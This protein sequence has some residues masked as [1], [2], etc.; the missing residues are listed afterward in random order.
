MGK[1]PLDT[2][3]FLSQDRTGQKHNATFPQ[4]ESCWNG[5]QPD[6]NGWVTSTVAGRAGHVGAQSR[7]TFAALLA[8]VAAQTG[9]LVA[10]RPARVDRVVPVLPRQD[11]FGGRHRLSHHRRLL[12]PRANADAG[13]IQLVIANGSDSGRPSGS[14][15]GRTRVG[16]RHLPSLLDGFGGSM[17]GSGNFDHLRN[18]MRNHVVASIDG[19]SFAAG[20]GTSVR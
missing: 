1:D 18:K 3:Q 5:I 20:R 8:A 14:S 17:D 9:R 11:R 15:F 13:P 2:L 4:L 19:Q 7:G 12:I 16:P 10:G 6:E